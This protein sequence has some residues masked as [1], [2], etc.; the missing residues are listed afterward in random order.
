MEG[1]LGETIATT[2]SVSCIALFGR[3]MKQAIGEVSPIGLTGYRILSYLEQNGD[4]AAPGDLVRATKLIPGTI[5]TSLNRLYDKEYIAK[6]KP[7]GT[8]SH[9]LYITDS[10]M[11]HLSPCD[12]AIVEAYDSFFEPLTD[13]LKSDLLSGSLVTSSFLGVTRMVGD[14]YF[15]EFSVLI[16]FLNSELYFTNTARLFGLGLGEYRVLLLLKEH[17]SASTQKAMRR[18]LL[19][20]PSELST[21]CRQLQEKGAIASTRTPGDRRSTSLVATAEGLQLADKIK[22]AVG[23]DMV[24]PTHASEI[25][26]YN[27]MFRIIMD[28]QRK[29]R[30]FR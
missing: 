1:A 27:G 17:P 24:R 16:G 8:A 18:I 12:E 22:A 6:D 20:H 28:Y 19:A 11:A 3:T 14:R 7:D 13:S 10:G 26:L 30:G 2:D 9:H 23:F 21:W 5:S 25:S 15:A 4:G 29:E